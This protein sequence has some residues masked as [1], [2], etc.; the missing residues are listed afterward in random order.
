MP[1][2]PIPREVRCFVYRRDRFRCRYCG[3]RVTFKSG[4][5]DHVIP[6]A[7]EGLT[8]E[9]NLATCC[10]SCNSIKGCKTLEALGWALLPCGMTRV[11]AE[12][13]CIALPVYPKRRTRQPKKRMTYP[14]RRFPAAMAC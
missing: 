11:Q 4:T 3:R 10:W 7:E 5:L 2:P 14:K 13:F 9:W 6:L 8:C 1:R 12:A